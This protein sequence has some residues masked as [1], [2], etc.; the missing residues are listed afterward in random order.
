MYRGLGNP[1]RLRILKLLSK[2]DR[3]SVSELAEELKITL[4]NTS[5]NLG[6]LLN[7]DLV[8]FEGRQ[9]RVY[10]S[11]HKRIASDVQQILKITLKR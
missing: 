2:T 11:L 5:R 1:N 7:L 3:I 6:I 9:D 8:E 10:Y 4:K